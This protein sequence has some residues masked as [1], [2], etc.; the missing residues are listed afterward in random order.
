MATRN[1]PAFKEG[2]VIIHFDYDCFYAA[3]FEAKNP[4]LKA[5]PFAVQQ[6]QIIVT[7]NYEARRRG[8]HKL[9]LIRDARRI[10]PEVIIELGEDISRFRDASKELYKFIEAYTWNGKVERLGFDEVWLDVTDMVVYNVEILNKNDLSHAFFQV[11]RE[12]PTVGFLFDAGAMAGH[13]YPKDYNYP[14][15]EAVDESTLRLR[16]GSHLAMY[17]RHELEQHKGYT[18]TVGVATNKLLAKLVG[19]LH[20]PKDQTTL[21][22]AANE[23]H[24][25]G[26]NAMAFIADHEIG[27]VPGIGFK[28][29]QKLRALILQRPADFDHGLIYGGTKE[30]VTIQMIR[31]CPEVNPEMLE[32]LLAGPGSQHGI[33]YK[34]WC[35]LHAVDDS[36]V[37]QMRTVPRQ[38]SIEDSYIRLDTLPEVIKELDTLAKS[39][40]TRMRVDLLGFEEVLEA[41][42]LGDD[43]DEVKAGSTD[44]K[45]WL[46]HP[47][48]LRLTTRP[49]QALLPDGTRPRSFKRISH[50]APLPNF[51]F[52]LTETIESLA[53]K[54]VKESLITMFRKI[55]PE[56]AGWNLSLVNLAVTNMAETAGNS[57]TANGRDISNMFKRQEDVLKGF[58][59]TDQGDA[60]T[61]AE[62][63]DDPS[64]QETPVEDD[65]Q[66]AENMA[67]KQDDDWDADE[68]EDAERCELLGAVVEVI[69]ELQER[70][71]VSVGISSSKQRL[72]S[73][74]ALSG[75][76]HTTPDLKA[77]RQQTTYPDGHTSLSITGPFLSQQSQDKDNNTPNTV[78]HKTPRSTPNNINPSSKILKMASNG[79]AQAFASGYVASANFPLTPEQHHQLVLTKMSDEEM[80]TYAS[81]AHAARAQEIAR[82]QAY[83]KVETALTDKTV[84]PAQIEVLLNDSLLTDRDVRNLF[85]VIR[86]AFLS[87]LWVH[88]E[89]EIWIKRAESY[90]VYYAFKMSAD[91]SVAALSMRNLFYREM[92]EQIDMVGK[93]IK[94][95][96]VNHAKVYRETC[97]SL[98]ILFANQ[99]A[100]QQDNAPEPAAGT[101]G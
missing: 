31:D 5:L 41:E 50:S 97:E 28:L 92:D 85:G 15:D 73:L 51:V 98:D 30:H 82:D 45:K 54:L 39:L 68:D 23:V 71:K 14:S 84:E 91:L 27:K 38:I 59:V 93:V 94:E 6:K 9:Q 65:I 3:V 101:S 19:N 99:A 35:L 62:V 78:T 95:E 100:I 79:S 34:V 8:L 66:D 74:R 12:D 76:I 36:E 86:E 47:K 44:G 4:S 2:R 57:K 96:V 60:T 25:C 69:S 89:T 64:L 80:A 40:I 81:Y 88:R 10:C 46:A 53:D 20:K 37:S 29:A 22:P 21:M 48:T 67:E 63:S 24:G 43:L 90:G 72:F 75:I 33:G 58:R 52:S 55:H 87:A 7:C 61:P 42:P 56:K 17:M 1:V 83:R 11:S 32:K 77:R 16:L 13:T 18:A 26:S 49:R 70:Q